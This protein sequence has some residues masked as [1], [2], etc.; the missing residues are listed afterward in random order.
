[1]LKIWCLL[2][3][4]PACLLTKAQKQVQYRSF[5]TIG[6]LAGDNKS[7]Y[8]VLTTHGVTYKTWYAGIGTGIDDYRNRSVPLILSLS[9]YLLAEN[10]LFVNINAG[11]NFIW[12]KSERNRLWNEIDSKAFPGLFAEAGFGYR[13]ETKKPGQ[14]ILFGTYYSYK[15]LKER[16]EVPG[17]CNN[18]PCDNTNEYIHSRF[19]R[20]AFKLGFVF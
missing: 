3:I 11:P 17:V 7:A 10:N 20:W 2:F 16:F 12:G 13:L 9:K 14:G 8:Q 4:L 15:N 1:M 19:S 18:P 6:I 5:N